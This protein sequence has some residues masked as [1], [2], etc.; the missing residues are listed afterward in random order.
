MMLRVLKFPLE[1]APQAAIGLREMFATVAAGRKLID[2]GSLFKYVVGQVVS[3]KDQ[4]NNT[5]FQMQFHENKLQ[6]FLFHDKGIKRVFHHKELHITICLDRESNQVKF[7]DREMK[8]VGR[9]LASKDKHE[10]RNPGIL[11]ASYC[12][13]YFRLGL[14]HDDQTITV[15][16]CKPFLDGDSEFF[17]NS[18]NEICQHTPKQM[19]SIYYLEMWGKWLLAA[20][21]DNSL[22]RFDPEKQKAEEQLEE[23][24]IGVVD[25]NLHDVL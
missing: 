20:A 21:E 16:N 14:I 12:E 13:I 6:D 9:Y 24:N 25:F 5:E 11:E 18:V 2:Y 19:R 1:V 7:Y 22:Y 8:L 17:L 4:V 10:G 23:V 15:M 3:V